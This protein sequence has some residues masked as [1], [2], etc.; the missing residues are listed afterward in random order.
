MEQ[1]YTFCRTL[2]AFS[3]PENAY[4]CKFRK[5]GGFVHRVKSKKKVADML[6]K[7]NFR[8][9]HDAGEVVYKGPKYLDDGILVYHGIV[10][11]PCDPDAQFVDVNT[12]GADGADGNNFNGLV[13]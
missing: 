11:S 9:R 8:V 13:V 4:I 6:S 12:H 5:D 1:V 10:G 7:Y 2:V 3:H